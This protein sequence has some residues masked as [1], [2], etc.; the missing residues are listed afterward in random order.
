MSNL[1]RSLTVALA[2]AGAATGVAYASADLPDVQTQGS[3]SFMSGGIGL[4]EST[5]MKQAQSQYPLSMLFIAKSSPRDVY[6]ADVSVTIKDA[7]GN[8]QL[9]TVTEGPYLLADL[10]SGKYTVTA[11]YNGRTET[12]NATVVTGQPRKLTFVW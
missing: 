9:D 12:R 4:D 10:P 11:E 6:T 1:Q 2:L 7:Q 3:V 5:A 8:T